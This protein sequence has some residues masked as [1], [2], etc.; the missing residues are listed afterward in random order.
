MLCK[1]EN[2]ENKPKVKVEERKF[3]SKSKISKAKLH[4]S[5]R[6]E[7]LIKIGDFERKA[8][9]KIFDFKNK[10]EEMKSS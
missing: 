7:I 1:A 5:R 4:Q 10:A 8:I 9:V 2:F 3:W 6:D